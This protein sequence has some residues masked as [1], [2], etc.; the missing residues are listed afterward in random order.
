MGEGEPLFIVTSWAWAIR[1][2]PSLSFWLPED[3]GVIG[4]FS[5]LEG[6]AGG[7]SGAGGRAGTGGGVG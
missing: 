4:G 7:V 1:Y 3:H 5:G 2:R 6:G